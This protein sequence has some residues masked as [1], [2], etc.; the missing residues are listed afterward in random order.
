MKKV[1]SLICLIIVFCALC[2]CGSKGIAYLQLYSYFLDSRLTAAVKCN[3]WF[4]GESV[5]FEKD[6]LSLP[7]IAKEIEN[8]P[9]GDYEV[10]KNTEKAI[11][12]EQSVSDSEKR[13]YM[14]CELESRNCFY[15]FDM[16]LILS[17][18]Q[19]KGE[20]YSCKILFPYHFSDSLVTEFLKVK[21]P[22][23]FAVE[24][25][26]DIELNGGITVDDLRDF[27]L[28]SGKLGVEETAN[29][30][31]L[32]SNDYQWDSVSFET[33]ENTPEFI[34]PVVKASVVKS[35]SVTVSFEVKENT[36]DGRVIIGIYRAE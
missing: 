25:G 1:I 2:G 21:E 9:K 12:V 32:Q 22:S 3:G 33:E 28:S 24:L 19:H 6:K 30:F 13:Y 15:A 35:A 11:A 5:L 18:K 27:Y 7:L 14:I 23:E 8:T 10:I 20:P 17:E 31:I 29:G 26:S 16:N 36:Q 34:A 4:T